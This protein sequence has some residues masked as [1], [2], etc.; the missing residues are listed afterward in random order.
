MEVITRFAPSPTGHLHLGHAFSALTAWHRARQ[1]GGRFLLRLEDID[2]TRCRPDF[3]TAILED[4]AWLGLDWDGEVRVQSAHLPEYRA[5]LDGL[6]TRGL[7]YP[8]FCTRADIAREVAGSAAAPHAPDGA[9]LYPGTCRRL[10]ADERATRIAAGQPFALRLD[11]ARALAAVPGELTVFEE[12]EGERRCDPARFGDAVLA[13]KDAP[14]SYHLCVTHD[15]ALQGVTLVTRGEDLR[16]ATDLHRLLQALMG[17]PVPCYAHH[18]LLTDAAG[19]RLA[20]R[21]R[22]ATLRELRADGVSPAQVRAPAG[23]PDQM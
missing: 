12:A 17:W 16:L 14:A 20:K 1:A 22:A 4:L 18:H 5:V 8:C 2:P 6:A 19:R 13:R 23:V 15:D 10:S 3:A 11:M 7:V 21:D 9:P